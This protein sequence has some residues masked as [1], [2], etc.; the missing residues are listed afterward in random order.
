M[1]DEPDAGAGFAEG[2]RDLVRRELQRTLG[3][4]DVKLS[5]EGADALRVRYAGREFV[6]TVRED[7]P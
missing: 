4:S 2:M 7:K 3:G 6:I 1:S 5:T